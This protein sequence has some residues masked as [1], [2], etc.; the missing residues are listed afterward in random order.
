M[1]E[2]QAAATAPG[3]DLYWIPLGAGAHVVRISGRMYEAIA[4]RLQRRARCASII[5]L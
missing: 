3:V 5:P 1:T 2:P 4:A